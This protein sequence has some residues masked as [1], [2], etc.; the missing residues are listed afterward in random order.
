[1]TNPDQNIPPEQTMEKNPD[2]TMENPRKT[3]DR[4]KTLTVI[5]SADLGGKLKLLNAWCSHLSR[6]DRK[7]KGNM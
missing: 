6:Y 7:N 4:P 5:Q 2:K 3:M 1:M